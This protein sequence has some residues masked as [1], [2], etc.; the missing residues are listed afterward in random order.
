MSVFWK[1]QLE[2]EARVV[3]GQFCFQWVEASQAV[4]RKDLLLNREE[5]REIHFIFE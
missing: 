5:I 1:L 2:R 3:S 4:F